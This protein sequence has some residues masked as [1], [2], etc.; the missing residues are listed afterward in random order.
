M[1]AMVAATGL[2]VEVCSQP[3]SIEPL[4]RVLIMNALPSVQALSKLDSGA[5]DTPADTSEHLLA[6][7]QHLTTAR[8]TVRASILIHDVVVHLVCVC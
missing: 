3:V 5:F 6:R 2:A 7:M 4:T 1:I 8:P